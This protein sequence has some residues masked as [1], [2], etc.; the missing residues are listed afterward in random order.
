MARK[1]QEQSSDVIDLGEYAE[2]MGQE[3]GGVVLH[4][5]AKYGKTTLAATIS[6]FVPEE[7]L[8]EP[9][10][11]K[12]V[13]RDCLWFSAD[14]G[15][16]QG[17]AD[18]G[19]E[20]PKDQTINLFK[21]AMAQKPLVAIETA[22]EMAKTIKRARPEIA[23]AVFDTV[24]SLNDIFEGWASAEA[25]SSTNKYARF[26][27]LMDYHREFFRTMRVLPGITPLWL[28]HS[29]ALMEG[30]ETTNSR[31]TRFTRSI[32]GDADIVAKVTGNNRGFYMNHADIIL[33]VRAEKERG[34]EITH[35][36]HA[37]PNDDQMEAGAR[38]MHRLGTDPL[39]FNLR[40]ILR[41]GGVLE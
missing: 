28:F 24:S 16:T 32:V 19:I 10:A 9:L 3:N 20:I 21:I 7:P 18:L 22:K 15:A 1:H 5:P 33:A 34:G 6:R 41:K 37:T 14:A 38:V 12:V 35:T 26:N 17:C 29:K 2:F 40:M 11:K 8:S 36:V 23:Y 31:N 25:A 4:A 30:E 13:A 27:K 39:P